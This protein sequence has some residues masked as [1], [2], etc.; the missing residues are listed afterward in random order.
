MPEFDLH[1]I[2][3]AIDID[4]ENLLHAYSTTIVEIK[5]AYNKRGILRKLF[6]IEL[7]EDEVKISFKDFKLSLTTERN[8]IFSGKKLFVRMNFNYK[9]E[10]KNATL[11]KLL[12]GNN[13]VIYVSAL[14]GEKLD[15]HQVDVGYEIFGL[16]AKT[17]HA[18]HIIS[19]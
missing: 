7:L 3:N 15:P 8:L 13:G 17:A 4:K 18:Q 2:S 5:E 12:M 10:D 16:L 19:I 6:E 9:L 14:D 1:T 11:L